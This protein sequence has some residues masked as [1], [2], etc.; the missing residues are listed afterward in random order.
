MPLLFITLHLIILGVYCRVVDMA[1]TDS[2][3]LATSEQA[4][5]LLKEVDA[6]FAKG[7]TRGLVGSIEIINPVIPGMV[8]KRLPPRVLFGNS[9]YRACIDPNFIVGARQHQVDCLS[10]VSFGCFEE[11]E[12]ALP[13]VN[14][15]S[16]YVVA[17]QGGFRLD[18]RCAV[19]R[20]DPRATLLIDIARQA[21]SLPVLGGVEQEEAEEL[22]D[23]LKEYNSCL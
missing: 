5:G 10:I 6:A 8:A 19:S 15:V 9:A 17:C 14:C 11:C 7:E 18:C 16:Y 4:E 3:L 21:P 13:E 20:R 23:F 2:I 1:R 22:I 12:I